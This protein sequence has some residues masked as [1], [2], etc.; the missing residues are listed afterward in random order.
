MSCHFPYIFTRPQL[1]QYTCRVNWHNFVFDPD[2]SKP[3]KPH[4]LTPQDCSVCW[5]LLFSLCPAF[6]VLS[7]LL[8]SLLVCHLCR[9]TGTYCICHFYPLS[10]SFFS[11]L[12]YFGNQNIFC[13][14]SLVDLNLLS[15]ASFK[16]LWDV[17]CYSVMMLYS[18]LQLMNL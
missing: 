10:L 16:V 12:Y 17:G 3:I 18:C 4:H 14:C 1:Q 11:S 2:S 5:M 15:S 9:K 6:A 8:S 7:S 13:F